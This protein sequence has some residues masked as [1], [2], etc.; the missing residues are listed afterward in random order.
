MASATGTEVYKAVS[1]RLLGYWCWARRVSFC[2]FVKH[3][4]RHH[5]ILHRGTEFRQHIQKYV[6]RTDNQLAFIHQRITDYAV[7]VIDLSG[8]LSEEGKQFLSLGRTFA[9]KQNQKTSRYE[10]KIFVNTNVNINI[11]SI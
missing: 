2:S 6:A 7:K 8:Q 9:V 10:W 11:S 1:S 3:L 5:E 4:S